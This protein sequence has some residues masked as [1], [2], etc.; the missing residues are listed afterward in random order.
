MCL[1]NG[2]DKKGSS[3]FCKELLAEHC[4]VIVSSDVCAFPTLSG[5]IVEEA[6]ELLLVFH[7]VVLL[8]SALNR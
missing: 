1:N 2:P 3:L 7:G 8:P 6:G 4:S 5:H